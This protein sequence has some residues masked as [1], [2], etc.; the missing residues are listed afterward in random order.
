MLQ[1]ESIY[2]LIPAKKIIPIRSAMH[3]S[4]YSPDIP[5]TYSS[6]VLNGSSYPGVSNCGGLKKL[7]RGAHESI[8]QSATFGRPIGSYAEDPKKFHKKGQ[9][10]K[11]L[12]PL[13]KLHPE[14]KM[15]KPP[16]PGINDKPIQGI[17]SNKNYIL[18]N[19]IDNILMRPKL[20]RNKSC[21]NIR[22]KFYGKIPDYIK[23]YRLEKENEINSQKELNK[24][25][26]EEE[27][28]KIKILSQ[29][30]IQN[31]KEGLTKVWQTYNFRY[32]NIT[33]KKLFDN[34]VLLRNKEGIEKDLSQIESYL[35]K[36]NAPKVI[37]DMTK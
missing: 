32:G 15:K 37:V 6:F 19:A 27:D 8:R 9:N 28:A 3:I 14:C 22:H 23:K 29:E 13:Q 21:E 12:P 30:E 17:K 34:L 11:I 26:K 7:P 2:N 16:I 20:N 25:L 24:R 5:P 33:H 36:L 35:Q 4:K 1:Q 10:C 18:S 31:L